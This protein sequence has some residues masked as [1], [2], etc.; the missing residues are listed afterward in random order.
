MKHPP[1]ITVAGIFVSRSRWAAAVV[2]FSRYRRIATVAGVAFGAPLSVPRMQAALVSLADWHEAQS[3]AAVSDLEECGWCP[4]SWNGLP[5]HAPLYQRD[6]LHRLDLTTT[7]KLTRYAMSLQ[8]S[9]GKRRAVRSA[10]PDPAARTSV[11][12]A[13]GCSIV[14]AYD[15]AKHL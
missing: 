1:A 6:V 15:V 13:V 8:Y 7:Q 5:V 14:A 9:L 2:R 3:I 11:A 4:A 10:V 12:F